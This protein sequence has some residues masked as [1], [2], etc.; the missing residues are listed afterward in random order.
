MIV[1]R[2]KMREEIARLLALL[3]SQP[4]DVIA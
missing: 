4:A 2:R 3:Q 1:D